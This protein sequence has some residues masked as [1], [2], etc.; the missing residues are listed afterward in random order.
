MSAITAR[1]LSGGLP[2]TDFLGL[3]STAV[4]R[5]SAVTNQICESFYYAAM[6]RKVAGDKPG[7]LNLLQKCLDT[8]D[9]NCMAYLSAGAEMKALKA[10]P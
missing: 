9:H 10:A 7:A 6:K 5:P 2:E 1:F 8:Q 4:K 3:A